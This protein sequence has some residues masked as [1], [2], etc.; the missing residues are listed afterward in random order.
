MT[1]PKNEDMQTFESFTGFDFDGTTCDPYQLQQT[2]LDDE[3]YIRSDAVTPP[4]DSLDQL[5]VASE[6]TGQ[7]GDM[8]IPG[9]GI[10]TSGS[11][12]PTNRSIRSSVRPQSYEVRQSQRTE[13][14]IINSQQVTILTEYPSGVV[15]PSSQGDFVCDECGKS[16]KR[17]PELKY[18]LPVYA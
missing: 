17:N 11:P 14:T 5:L 4:F 13:T 6:N 10:P 1:T 2:Y 7:H 3:E 18:V 15:A 9:Y 12:Y 16:Y 8:Y